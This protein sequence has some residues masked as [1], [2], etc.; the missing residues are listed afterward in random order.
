VACRCCLVPAR[1]PRSAELSGAASHVLGTKPWGEG[2]GGTSPCSSPAGI[3]RGPVAPRI[4]M[5]GASDWLS[6][7]FRALHGCLGNRVAPPHSAD[8]RPKQ[9]SPARR[10]SATGTLFLESQTWGHMPQG[11]GPQG[12]KY[13]GVGTVGRGIA[14][15]ETKGM[16]TSR[17]GAT[18]MDGHCRGGES[19]NR[20]H[21]DGEVSVHL[22]RQ[23]EM[24]LKG[25]ISGKMAPKGA[26]SRQL[27]N[28]GRALEASCHPSEGGFGLD[29]WHCS[30]GSL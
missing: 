4:R 9:P 1:D 7:G 30:A 12:W 10:S 8:R 22:T 18:G 27:V 6:L 21:G 17:V 2:V 19:R 14:A 29:L 23:M 28:G 16:R 5:P 20:D 24:M 11:Q 15:T 3:L 13:Q 26:W 25:T